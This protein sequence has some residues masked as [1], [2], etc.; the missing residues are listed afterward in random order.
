MKWK[1]DATGP[2]EPIDWARL[3]IDAFR[4]ETP[5]EWRKAARQEL[6]RLIQDVEQNRGRPDEEG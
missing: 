2:L 1:S 4:V 3:F 5:E 6:I